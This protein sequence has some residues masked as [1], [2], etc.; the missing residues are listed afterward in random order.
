MLSKIV[1]SLAL[2]ATFLLLGGCV[3]SNHPLSSEG[4]LPLGSPLIGTWIMVENDKA[5]EKGTASFVHIG[6]EKEAVRLNIINFK[7]GEIDSESY[8]AIPTELDG[9]SYLSIQYPYPINQVKNTDPSNQ[10]K[11]T[12]DPKYILCKYQ[13]SPDN[14]LV[15]WLANTD[16]IKDAVKKEL[17]RG[18]IESGDVFLSDDQQ[19]LRDFISKN[20]SS[21]FN[22]LTFALER[23][24]AR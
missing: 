11:N 14:R 1:K 2:S 16:F 15:V 13:I 19:T 10:K 21:I 8:S 9:N 7:G 3:M 17:L 23:I 12:D 18:R 24:E 5:K 20:D 22:E 6:N 4:H